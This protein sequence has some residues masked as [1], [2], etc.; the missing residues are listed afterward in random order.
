MSKNS[1]L[2]SDAIVQLSKTIRSA[3]PSG[4]AVEFP[5]DFAIGFADV[6]V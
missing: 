5:D 2:R 3:K 6:E 1:R 4:N